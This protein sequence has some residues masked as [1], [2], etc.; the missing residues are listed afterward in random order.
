MK[1]VI[2]AVL[3]IGLFWPDL[4]VANSLKRS[5]RE[6]IL[7]QAANQNGYKLPEEIN[8]SFDAKKSALGKIFFETENGETGVA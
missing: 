6:Q 2:N 4:L 1:Y 3:L 7:H 8:R 5:Y